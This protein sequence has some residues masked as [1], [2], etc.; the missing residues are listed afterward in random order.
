MPHDWRHGH[1]RKGTSGRT[2]R[3][4]AA[5]DYGIDYLEI[6]EHFNALRELIPTLYGSARR[7]LW[8]CYKNLDALPAH[9]DFVE[10]FLCI[11]QKPEK[12]TSGTKLL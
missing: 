6:A 7:F 9:G 12:S 8:Y 11:T 1:D 3:N 2:T 5:H 4:L 10:S